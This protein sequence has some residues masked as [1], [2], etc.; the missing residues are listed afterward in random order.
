MK[1]TIG[2]LTLGS[3]IGVVFGVAIGNVVSSERKAER[4]VCMEIA[5]DVTAG[6]VTRSAYMGTRCS[7]RLLI[8][9]NDHDAHH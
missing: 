2:M 8:Q 3:M 5:M 4:Q 7:A 9:G 6:V 1:M